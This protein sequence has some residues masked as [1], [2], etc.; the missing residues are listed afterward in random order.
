MGKELGTCYQTVFSL[1]EGLANL[2]SV[3]FVRLLIFHIASFP[4][5]DG[6]AF[7]L[8]GDWPT[9]LRW[10]NTKRAPIQKTD[11]RH[12][13]PAVTVAAGSDSNPG[14][15]TLALTIPLGTKS[16]LGCADR[17]T[18]PWHIPDPWQP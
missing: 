5:G 10:P 17:L 1:L 18:V 4:D 6:I 3:A 15:A 9:F 8:A 11:S 7:L 16:G 2:D 12:P 14:G 13:S